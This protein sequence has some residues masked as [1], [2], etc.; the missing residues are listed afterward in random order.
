MLALIVH[1]ETTEERVSQE[2]PYMLFYE[3]QGLDKDYAQ[4]RAK[5]QGKRQDI[6]NTEDDKMFD[7]ALK[8]LRN[9]CCIQ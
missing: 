9:R 7:E 6:G 5:N 3:L 2:S 8:G 1:Q 4:F